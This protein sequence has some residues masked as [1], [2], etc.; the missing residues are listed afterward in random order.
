MFTSN[1]P[2]TLGAPGA[3]ANNSRHQF[4]AALNASFDT[5]ESLLTKSNTNGKNL[6]QAKLNYTNLMK[7][8]KLEESCKPEFFLL[9]VP[10]PKAA[11]HPSAQSTE[12]LNRTVDVCTREHKREENI[13]D[14]YGKSSSPSANSILLKNGRNK[15]VLMGRI[16]FCLKMHKV[17]PTMEAL[18]DVYGQ[19]KKITKGKQRGENILLLRN[20]DG[21]PVLQ[22]AY[23]EFAFN[24]FEAGCCLRAVGRFVAENRLHAFK[25]KKLNVENYLKSM[26]HFVRIQ[27]V[28]SF[29]LLQ[30]EK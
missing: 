11:V 9:P 8:P 1:K 30:N 28:S 2:K 12:K 14:F 17:Y 27:N 25:L 13:V 4:V 16:D 23:Y 21:G 18:W 24:G 6:K 7:R 15:M 22:C 10:Q 5:A 3:R 29:A 20:T 19:L 26:E